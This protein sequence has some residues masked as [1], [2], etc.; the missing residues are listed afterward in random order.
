MK[1]DAPRGEGSDRGNAKRMAERAAYLEPPLQRSRNRGLGK[2]HV[3][4][5]AVL[6]ASWVPKH[7]KHAR[8]LQP[9][10]A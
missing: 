10:Q 3:A 9:P 7:H 6:G 4:T 8:L 1:S 2:L 5:L